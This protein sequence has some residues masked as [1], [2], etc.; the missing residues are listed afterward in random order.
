MPSAPWIQKSAVV[1]AALGMSLIACLAPVLSALQSTPTPQPTFTLQPTQTEQ[2]TYTPLPTYTAFPTYTPQPS[3]TFMVLYTA[4]ILPTDTPWPTQYWKVT[5]Q[6]WNWTE[7]PINLYRYEPNGEL[8]FL[9][10]LLLNGYYG[11][12]P[13]PDLGEWDIRWC[14]RLEDGEDFGCDE[15]TIYVQESGQQFQVP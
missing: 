8:K 9:G 3:P 5:V 6:I 1:I 4:P 2:P 14:E 13:F 7:G 12:Y 10:Y 11:L 15:K